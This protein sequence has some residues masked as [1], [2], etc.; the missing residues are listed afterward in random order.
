[1]TSDQAAHRVSCASAGPVVG[2]HVY[3]G[4]IGKM[5]R[6]AYN[7]KTGEAKEFMSGWG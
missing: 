3:G 4:G 7:E 2:V 6:R 1:M 5:Q